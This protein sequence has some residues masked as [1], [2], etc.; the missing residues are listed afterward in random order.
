MILVVSELLSQEQD[1][2]RYGCAGAG[3]HVHELPCV[4]QQFP[5]GGK[6]GTKITL[7]SSKL[8]HGVQLRIEQSD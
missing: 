8:Q 7:P 6:N 2:C 4:P 1:F 3:D 5:N